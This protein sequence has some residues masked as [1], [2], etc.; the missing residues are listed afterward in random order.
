MWNTWAGV[1]G[2]TTSMLLSRG[3]RNR[4][5]RAE[6]AQALAFMSVRRREHEGPLRQAHFFS[7][8]AMN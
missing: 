8:D 2:L 5:S 7:A 4:S 3:W 1:V 6:G